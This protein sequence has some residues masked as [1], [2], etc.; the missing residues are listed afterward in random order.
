MVLGCDEEPVKSVEMEKSDVLFVEMGW[1]GGLELGVCN[2]GGM[3]GVMWGPLSLVG[4]V[5]ARLFL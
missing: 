3:L 5:L 2:Q 1:Y 4:L